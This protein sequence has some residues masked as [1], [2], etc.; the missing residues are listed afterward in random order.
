[1]P[2]SP[3][4]V[5]REH[6]LERLNSFLS[7]ALAGQSQ[8]CFLTGEAGSGKTALATEF[9]RIAQEKNKN[10]LVAFGQSD[11]ITGIGDPYLPFR[12][13]LGALT[14]DVEKMLTRG[15]ITKKNATRLNGFLQFSIGMLVD[16]GPDLI[17]LF[18]PGSGLITKIGVDIAEN[19]GLV[20][21]LKQ[22]AVRQ[23]ELGT[24][25]SSGIK[26]EHIFEQYTNVMKAMSKKQ[27]LLLIVDDLHWTDASSAELLFHL[28]RRLGDSQIMVLG[29]Y[30]PD[31]VALGRKG[32]RHPLEKALVELK[33]YFGDTRVELD[34]TDEAEKQK[35]ITSFLATEPNRLSE[36]FT[37]AL[38]HHTGGHP[39]FTV[40]LLRTMQERGALVKDD[41][42]QWVEGSG[43]NWD[44]FPPR[45]EGV[46]EERI[47]RLEEKQRKVLSVA[48]VEGEQFTAE[49]VAKVQKVAMLELSQQ[50]GGEL[51]KKYRLVNAMG[52][53]PLGANRLSLFRFYHN[54]FQKYLY[55]TLSEMERVYLH[56]A[57]GNVLED[58]YA[59]HVNKIAEQLAWHFS[60]AGL[61]E[62]AAHYLF[63]AGK[64]AAV[65]YANVEALE[66][67]NR[68]LELTPEKD[69]SG[70]FSILMAHEEVLSLMGNRNLQSQDLTVLHTLAD[71]LNDD[72][73]RIDVALRL[74]SFARYTSDYSTAIESAQTAIKL[75][76]S[77]GN[78]NKQAQANIQLANAYSQMRAPK[79]AL[80]FAKRGLELFRQIGNRVGEAKALNALGNIVSHSH[81]NDA[82][83]YYQEAIKIAQSLNAEEVEAGATANLAQILMGQLDYINALP[84]FEKSSKI[85][86]KTGNRRFFG[87]NQNDL[88]CVFLFL[89][90]L[91]EARLYLENALSIDRETNANPA[92][93]IINLCELFNITG[94][95]LRSYEYCQEAL[96]DDRV[97]DFYKGYIFTCLGDSLLGLGRLDEAYDVFQQAVDLRRNRESQSSVVMESLAGMG[98]VAQARGELPEA[99]IHI[100]EI[101][102]YLKDGTLEGTEEP[103]KIYITCYSILKANHD[104][105]SIEILSIA[106][107]QLQE[108]AAKISDE[109]FRRSFLENISAHRQ[110]VSEWHSTNQK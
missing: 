47:N 104:H 40:E 35:F 15:V 16:Y 7:Q 74:T 55:G 51:G 61:Q 42:G 14:G 2:P 90:K 13:I 99:C 102:N 94:D 84:L 95:Y 52:V 9:S 79:D 73:L 63:E 3:V 31:E 30:R 26:Q 109:A 72:S 67:F 62:K 37:Q 89:G 6:E 49:V 24:V 77:T 71:T 20:E 59:E 64:Q 44:S 4:F 103:F 5:A 1:M 56:E 91:D 39:L 60:E 107:N 23:N 48:S 83:V 66:Y 68:A 17:N 76:E 50:L 87:N 110:I 93:T 81:P 12:E 45:V 92:Q 10:L 88:G 33:R 75:A 58:L 32:E 38:Y 53:Q 36:K 96:Q 46:I 69:W 65:R 27:P 100:E 70:R 108:K 22:R 25:G 21:K 28:G 97:D 101:L 86:N 78:L 106:Y 98:R 105:R 85:N 43:L 80:P 54:L 57:V 41:R 34:T 29:T 18:V 11:A 82:K 8:V 19:A